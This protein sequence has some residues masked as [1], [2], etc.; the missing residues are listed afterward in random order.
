MQR[1]F[2]LLS[3]F[4]IVLCT[5]SRASAV[6]GFMLGLEFGGGPWSVNSSDIVTKS[7]NN[8]A[9]LEGQPAAFAAPLNEGW[10]PSLNLHLGW[11]IL[12]HVAVEA[13]FNTSFWSVTTASRG[14]SGLVGGRATW[15]P[16]QIFLPHRIFD[17]GIELGGGYSIAGG[18]QYGMDGGYFQFG[19]TA[20]YYPTPNVSIGAFY[21]FYQP[22]WDRFFL[23]YNNNVSAATPGF[24]ASLNTIGITATIHVGG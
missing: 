4:A 7:N 20:E 1:R 3:A 9:L 14:G 8:P 11:N 2:A 5:S 22:H 19:L 23:D 12:G 15:Y 6:S 18:P 21:R 13:A 24:T 17:V 16:L 10:N